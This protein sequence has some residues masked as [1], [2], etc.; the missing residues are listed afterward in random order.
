MKNKER[1]RKKLQGLFMRD[2]PFKK[3]GRNEK[4]KYWRH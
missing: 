3:K 1:R 4:I 2:K